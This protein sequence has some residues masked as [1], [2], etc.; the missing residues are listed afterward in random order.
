MTFGYFLKAIQPVDNKA[1]P[2]IADTTDCVENSRNIP[3]EFWI[4][5]A[6]LEKSVYPHR[7]T[8]L[9]R[10]NTELVIAKMKISHISHVY[11]YIHIAY[12]YII[13][14]SPRNKSCGFILFIPTWSFF[15]KMLQSHWWRS[16]CSCTQLPAAKDHRFRWLLKYYWCVLTCIRKKLPIFAVC[17]LFSYS[18]KWHVGFKHMD[19]VFTKCVFM[20]NENI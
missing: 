19:Y 13:I 6:S 9:K 14:F 5:T 12:W 18:G 8:T 15:E 11:I 3:R 1:L 16:R 2:L 20:T 10:A 4:M 7:W 17:W